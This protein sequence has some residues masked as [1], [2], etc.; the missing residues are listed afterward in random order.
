MPRKVALKNVRNIGFVAHIDAGKTTTTERVLYFTGVSHKIGEVHDGQATMDFMA[1]EQERGIT[2]TSAATTCFWNG[3]RINIIDTPGHVDF[4][5][6]VERSLRVLDGVVG[7]FCAV[8][9]VEPQSETVWRQADKH[10]VPRIAFVNKMDRTGADLKRTVRMMK[11]RLGCRPVL[12]QLP[13]GEEDE[14]EGVI[15][16]VNMKALYY[17][18][19][20]DGPIREADIPADMLD[21]AQALRVEL[22]ETAAES[23]EELT[24][25]YLSGEELSPAEVV[26]GLRAGVLSMDIV[27]VMCG[28]AFKNKGVEPLLDAVVDYLPSPLDVPAMVGQGPD[29]GEIVCPAEDDAPLA[30]IAFKLMSDP[31]I[32]HLTFIRIYS[33]SL[34]AGSHVYNATRGRK[35]RIGRL[36]KMHADQREEI[37][38]VFA[39]DIV[40]AVGLKSAATGDTLTD[41]ANQVVLQAIEAPP[42][43]ISI[44]VKPAKREDGDKMSSAL[45]RLRAEDPSLKVATDHESG[46]T[47]L[48][49]MGELH[50]DIVVDRLRREFGCQVDVDQPEVAYREGLSAEAEQRLKYAKQSGG[51]G[52]YADVELRVIP[53]ERGE[54]FTFVSKIVGGSIP[55][56]FIPAVERG[57]RGAAAGGILA[58]YPIEDVKVELFDGSFHAVDSS[59][60]AFKLAGSMAF[61]KAA[62]KARP[63]LLEPIMKLEVVTPDEFIGQVVGDINSRRGRISGM[64]SRGAVQVVNAETPLSGMFGYA[65]DLRSDTQGRAVFSMQFSHYEPAP[66]SV[67]DEVVGRKGRKE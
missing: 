48:S 60:L 41:A 35:E 63:Q 56:E 23:D 19:A 10:K 51:R 20:A 25:R 62:A 67:V 45:G 32:G 28:S 37:K 4:T 47:V 64:E 46:Q 29:G 40:A 14:F 24:D 8:G 31:Y 18:G 42:T 5:I 2:I 54:G 43:V 15:D 16:L 22:V 9:G 49:G 50:L 55:K 53:Q 44:A 59:D 65:T 27:P 39:G 66:A 58:G 12:L 17:D 33:G 21:E 61:K 7:V 26:A 57:V 13:I 1:Q 30:A 38:E 34:T 11:D 52:Q 36:L 3:R 6:E